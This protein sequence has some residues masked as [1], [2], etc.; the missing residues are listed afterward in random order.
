[1]GSI[2]LNQ[3]FGDVTLPTQILGVIIAGPGAPATFHESR[4][5]SV[6]R[7]LRRPQS[8]FGGLAMTI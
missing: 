8:A 3:H 2:G 1:M 6:M 7:L 4:Y 5:Y